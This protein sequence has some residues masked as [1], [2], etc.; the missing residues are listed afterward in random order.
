M[1]FEDRVRISSADEAQWGKLVKSW[2]TGKNYFD[3]TE[4]AIPVPTSIDELKQQCARFNI[5]ITVPAN[6][7]NLKVIND[8]ADTLTIKLPMASRIADSEQAITRPG[9]YPLP[10]CY[11]QFLRHPSQMSKMDFHA[12]RIGDYT[13]SNCV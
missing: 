2:A 12:C 13:I 6:I 9:G 3:A 8:T 7:V 1:P 11:E 5:T 10:A 4:P